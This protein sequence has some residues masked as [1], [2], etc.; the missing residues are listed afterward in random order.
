METNIYIREFQKVL[1][2]TTNKTYLIQ[3][4]IRQIEKVISSINRPRTM[5][6]S[7][8]P[9]SPGVQTNGVFKLNHTPHNLFNEVC[10]H[11]LI[12]K[13]YDFNLIPDDRFK[14]RDIKI[15]KDGINFAKYYLWLKD[16]LE[17]LTE[18]KKVKKSNLSH[19]QKMLVLNYLFPEINKFE[20][21]KLAN[22]LYDV[23]DESVDNTR[24]YLSYISDGKNKVRTKF[25][26]EK[27]LK[28]FENQNFSDI[29]NKI[30]EDIKNLK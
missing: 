12:N 9:P 5:T 10:H 23:I 20:N 7:L 11:Y 29:S 14:E 2:D 3:N 13:D 8:I 25:N 21:K 6:P 4:E 27:I 24:Q 1:I 26:L 17:N 18:T 16:E 28:L 22:I 15:A 30:K 19:K